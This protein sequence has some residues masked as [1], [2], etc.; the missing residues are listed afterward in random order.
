MSDDF[1]EV[2]RNISFFLVSLRNSLDRPFRSSSNFASQERKKFLQS[3]MIVEEARV[4]FNSYVR[5][6]PE[7][8]VQEW[9][10]A[11]QGL[12]DFANSFMNSEVIDESVLGRRF[13]PSPVGRAERGDPSEFVSQ[14][15]SEN[16]EGRMTSRMAVGDAFGI[17][18]AYLESGALDVV[19]LQRDLNFSQLGRIVPKQ[20]VAPVRF[21]IKNNQICIVQQA[22]EIEPEDALNVQSAWEHLQS[23]GEE[24]ISN[25]ELSNCDRRLLMAAK[26]LHR[27]VSTRENIIKAGLSNLAFSEMSKQFDCELPDAVNAMITSYCSAVSLYAAQFPEWDQFTENAISVHLD[28]EDIAE[29]ESTAGQLVDNLLGNPEL[30]EPEVPKTIELIREMVSSPNK[31]SKRAAFALIR[32]VENF[33]SSILHFGLKFI[34]STGEKV[35]E[36]GST[37]TAKVLVGLLSVALVGA[38]GIGNA[39]IN[40]GTPWVKQAAEIVEKQI[41]KIQE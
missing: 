22:N 30:A 41:A 3:I 15:Y 20:Q 14:F 2:R 31:S 39:A 25:L 4:L 33:V 21:E 7:P 28:S 10:E 5:F 27:Q 1:G 26:E 34:S 8:S 19:G 16:S 37:M 40:A 13:V 23:A 32:T 38:S 18:V 24:I 17:F 36:A 9:R 35:I 11:R 6:R 12:I 29:V